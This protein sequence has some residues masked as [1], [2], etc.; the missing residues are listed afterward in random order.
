MPD[1]K[2]NPWDN[3][4]PAIDGLTKHASRYDTHVDCA[5]E[6]QVAF[7]RLGIL[8]RKALNES[9]IRISSADTVRYATMMAQGRPINSPQMDKRLAD[10]IRSQTP[11]I[12]AR[13]KL[14]DEQHV[15][16]IDP[17]DAIK[18][19]V[20]RAMNPGQRVR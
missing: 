12:L 15:A 8:T 18:R 17:K 2:Q 20:D 19:I 16:A 13:I 3:A 6:D 11:S 5:I 14:A 4:G 9:P 1:E 7:D 10:L